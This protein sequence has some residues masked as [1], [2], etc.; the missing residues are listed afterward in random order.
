MT[1]SS[2]PLIPPRAFGEAHQETAAWTDDVAALRPDPEP[3]GDAQLVALR[4][5]G[6]DEHC[7]G[8]RQA[9]ADALAGTSPE[10]EVREPRT[11]HGAVGGEPV[12]IEAIWFLPERGMALH[13]VRPEGHH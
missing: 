1:S 8:Q 5:G 3:G 12:R 2:S 7:L 10:R 13:R 6:D 4:D 11:A 9:L